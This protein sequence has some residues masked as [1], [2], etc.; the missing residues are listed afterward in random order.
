MTLHLP[1]ELEWL[2]YLVG[3]EWPEG[4]EDQMWALA[5][6]WRNAAAGLRDQLSSIA[7]AKS[8]TLAAYVNGDGR[9]EMA[10]LF[11]KLAA[12][13]SGDGQGNSILD[14][15]EHFQKLG[16]S[17]EETG[18]EIQ[19]TKLMFYS[20]IAMAAAE[21]IG[22]WLWPPTAP[23]VEAVIVTMTR[24]AVRII[25][26]EALDRILAIAAR[27]G[28]TA[29]VKFAMK[30]MV[31]NT[32]LGTL[33][34]YGI[35]QY[36]VDTGHRKSVNW[37]Q[38]GVTAISSGVG[39]AVAGPIGGA[40][41][42][43]L[44]QRGV[45]RYLTGLITGTSAGLVGG[46]AG[47]A[48]ATAAQFGFDVAQHG[49]DNAVENLKNTHFDPRMLTGGMFQGAVS[50]VNHTG[51]HTVWETKVTRMSAGI[52]PGDLTLVGSRPDTPGV[53]GTGGTHDPGTNGTT[54]SNGTNGSS[55]YNGSNGSDGSHTQTGPG[56]DGSRM[57]PASAAGGDP[58]GDT[59]ARQTGDGSTSRPDTT[60]QNGGGVTTD[61]RGTDRATPTDQGGNAQPGPANTS[62]ST[63]QTH[64]G[65]DATG[66]G[67]E[68]VSRPQA[69]APD[70]TAP[71]QSGIQGGTHDTA[72]AAPTSTA[73][74]NG[75]SPA[76]AA[77]S[78]TG[79]SSSA[80]GGSS[81]A[82][83]SSSTG[84][85]PSN[86]G[87]SSNTGGGS[88]NT[89]VGSSNAG[90]GASPGASGAATH[91][92]ASTAGGTSSTGSDAPTRAGS[93][94][95]AAD[96][97][98]SG[99]RAAA[100]GTTPG[101]PGSASAAS[102]PAGATA[103]GGSPS[104]PV[105]ASSGANAAPGS[106]IS[107]SS[108]TQ[109]AGSATQSATPDQRAASP[110]AG[111]ATT[112]PKPADASRADAPKTDAQR[113]EAP[114]SDTPAS[115]CFEVG[116]SAF[117]HHPARQ[118]AAR[119]P[120]RCFR[121]PHGCPG[122]ALR[123]NAFRVHRRGISSRRPRG[124][125]SRWRVIRGDHH[126]TGRPRHRIRFGK[127]RWYTGFEQSFRADRRHHRAPRW[128]RREHR[129]PREQAGHPRRSPRR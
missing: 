53:N 1:S 13:A 98:A 121:R 64:G 106:S 93:T 61:S 50:G 49:W 100:P 76:P 116:K 80:G 62:G 44:G 94:G 95:G 81:N 25:G 42:N 57:H 90:G 23:M 117:R 75:G 9:D 125:P 26:R 14:L 34:D 67:G 109:H 5:E 24:I 103:A 59:G 7:D 77:S 89:G 36:Q 16:D 37:T 35:Q 55:G 119:Q 118:P 96:T 84:G 120:H 43:S 128:F 69:G 2:G 18:T 108:T 38:V 87:G 82:G 31:M 47:F 91:P 45:N 10:Q 46:A 11:D 58:T 111:E 102:S 104:S 39:G 56:S 101:G 22:A 68:S 3:V 15:A 71:L 70:S 52:S 99:A 48:G 41:G 126:P 85:S 112:T 124:Y 51:A 30:H 113:A 28:I 27:M 6:D 29:V 88:S 123:R 33:Q 54:G 105:A 107:G 63:P 40:I 78:T 17:V 115:R 122:T 32:V 127:D 65:I 19:Y 129:P 66:A 79:G 110:R 72:S 4:D 60:A 20:S 12:P 74:T 21:I 92:A 114:K 97:S 8:A 73:A 86:T 83:G